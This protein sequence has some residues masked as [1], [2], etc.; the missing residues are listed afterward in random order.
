MLNKKYM[1][2]ETYSEEGL[3]AHLSDIFHTLVDRVGKTA[4]FIKD[5]KKANRTIEEKLDLINGEWSNSSF[6]E[7]LKFREGEVKFGGKYPVNTLDKMKPEIDKIRKSL[8]VASRENKILVKRRTK[9]LKE[10]IRFLEGGEDHVLSPATISDYRKKLLSE[11]NQIDNIARE[12]KSL[13]KSIAAALTTA[14]TTVLPKTGLIEELVNNPY[15]LVEQ[16]KDIA[17][18][19]ETPAKGKQKLLTAENF[20][21]HVSFLKDSIEVIE[22][23]T[24]EPVNEWDREVGEWFPINKFGE[25]SDFDKITDIINLIGNSPRVSKEAKEEIRKFLDEIVFREFR[26]F[27]TALWGKYNKNL[28]FLEKSIDRVFHLCQS[29]YD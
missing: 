24:N 28:R 10:A 19:F 23:F 6:V 18:F 12:N 15:R 4:N 22:S 21:D 11:L 1:P 9:I 20:D 29:S 8:I 13:G 27:V 5:R 16:N 7:D 2:K 17:E 14:A 26:Y 25:I 3:A